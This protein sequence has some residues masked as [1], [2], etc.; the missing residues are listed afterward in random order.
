MK[1][2]EIQLDKI[3]ES[4]IKRKDEEDGKHKDSEEWRNYFM[5]WLEDPELVL[6]NKNCGEEE[7]VQEEGI[8][9][10][11]EKGMEWIEGRRRIECRGKADVKEKK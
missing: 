5:D 10:R 8:E 1:E 2:R 4:R 9:S 3:Y 11:K 6:R 7:E